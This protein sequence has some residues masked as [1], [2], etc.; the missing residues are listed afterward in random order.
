MRLWSLTNHGPARF[1]QQ[2]Q[3]FISYGTN[4]GLPDLTLQRNAHSVAADGTLYL[5][6]ANGTVVSKFDPDTERLS[7]PNVKLSKVLID[8]A[9]YTI[10]YSGEVS[11]INLAADYRELVL[12]FS[13]LDYREPEKNTI[14]Y[15][16]LGLSS[17]W[18]SASRNRELRYVNLPA[19]Q[20][21]LEVEGQNSLS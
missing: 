4:D 18:S 21:Q 9:N 13:V 14:R 19:G 15:R 7:V 5:G 17:A 8:G 20:Y 3:R 11:E 16:L 6:T 12:G 2:I 10:Q 1:D